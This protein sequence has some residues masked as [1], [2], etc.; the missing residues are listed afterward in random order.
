MT[1]YAYPSLVEVI[2]HDTTGYHQ[3][4]E[5]EGWSDKEPLVVRTVG[6]LAQK[7]KL[8]VQLVT[9]MRD[10]GV[11]GDLFIIPRGAVV[12]IRKLGDFIEGEK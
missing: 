12:Q 3:W 11:A 7:N 10:D 8:M 6:Y 1:I 5:S 9:S 4:F 2:W